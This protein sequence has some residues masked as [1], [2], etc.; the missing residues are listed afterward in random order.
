MQPELSFVNHFC[1]FKKEIH[2]I[3]IQWRKQKQIKPLVFMNFQ[4]VTLN[5]SWLIKR[6]RM[7]QM[8][9][10]LALIFPTHDWWHCQVSRAAWPCHPATQSQ[11]SWLYGSVLCGGRPGCSGLQVKQSRVATCR[12]GPWMHGIKLWPFLSVMWLQFET[13]NENASVTCFISVRAG[14]RTELCTVELKQ[15]QQLACFHLFLPFFSNTVVIN[16][17]GY[18]V[19]KS[20]IVGSCRVPQNWYL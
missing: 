18:V 14:L 1:I 6:E 8:G 13:K 10:R 4:T 11:W 19:F 7:P 3:M 2:N 9:L 17:W 5:L 15:L 20:V 12:H 16:V